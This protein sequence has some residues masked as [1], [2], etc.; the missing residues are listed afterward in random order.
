MAGT[1]FVS[2]RHGANN[3]GVWQY[4]WQMRIPYDLATECAKNLHGI[5]WPRIGWLG[6]GGAQMALL[7]VLRNHV[8]GWFIHPLGLILCSLGLADGGAHQFVF[9]GLIVWG[10]K[11]L[12]LRLGGVETYERY[13]ALFAGFV[14]GGFFPAALTFLVNIVYFLVKGRPLA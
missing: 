6:I 8:V 14:I 2:Y 5:D 9:T 12:F 4:Q 7:I 3:F 13:K 10:L 11:T 1:L